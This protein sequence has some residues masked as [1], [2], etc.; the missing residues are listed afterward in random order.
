MTTALYE[1]KYDYELR[2]GIN[3]FDALT[4]KV[5]ICVDNGGREAGIGFGEYLLYEGKIDEYELELALNF[6]KQKH[7]ALGVLAVQERFL[8]DSQLC[9]VLDYQRLKGKGLF[10]EIAIELG[11]L[12]KDEVDTLL[13]MQKEKHIRIGDVLVLF[14]SVTREDMEEALKGFHGLM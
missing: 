13:G 14:G 5:A 8:D 11:F 1:T 2:D 10:G 6:Q 12:S 9:A 7:A 3:T 4:R